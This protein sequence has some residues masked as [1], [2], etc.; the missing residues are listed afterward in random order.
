MTLRDK[1]RS[2]HHGMPAGFQFVELDGKDVL[3]LR[4]VPFELE[5]IISRWL[6]TLSDE[7]EMP[8]VL[9]KVLQS[10]PE[11]GLALTEI[12]WSAF[13]SWMTESLNNVQRQPAFIYESQSI[14]RRL[15][16]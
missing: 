8:G 15:F 10:H 4:D 12:G 14:W 9:I 16:D 7:K 3:P 5:E 13:L 11:K 6:L 2:L 1:T